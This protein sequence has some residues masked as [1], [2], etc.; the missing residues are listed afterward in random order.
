MAYADWTY[1][2]SLYSGVAEADYN[3]RAWDASQLMDYHTTGVDGVAKL[4][5]HLP[6]D[7]YDLEA[8]KRCCCALI[9]LMVK[10]DAAEAA[11]GLVARADGT[12]SGKIVSSV[13]SGSESISYSTAAVTA[14]DKAVADRSARDTL[15]S[16]IVRHY[17][18]GVHDS[19]GVNLLYMGAYP[20]V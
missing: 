15:Y 13:S 18:S 5:K 8:V 1:F 14:F 6:T 16:D 20:D 9:D 17:L 3:R 19:N 4:R 10:V 7:E 11:S 12:V 2:H